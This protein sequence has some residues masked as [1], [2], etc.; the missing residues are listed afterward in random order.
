MKYPGDKSKVTFKTW[1][2]TYL[3]AEADGTLNHEDM[4]IDAKAQWTPELYTSPY[5]Y[6]NYYSFKGAQG[7]YMVCE[8]NGVASANRLIADTWERWEVWKA[9]D[10]NCGT[11]CIHLRSYQ[12][13]TYLCA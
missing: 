5:T 4:T 2:G 10:C 11:S 8:E 12:W 7:M 1:R 13:G 6:Y 3:S 9:D